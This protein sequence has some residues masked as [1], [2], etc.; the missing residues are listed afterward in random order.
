M[1]QHFTSFVISFHR[2]WN[3]RELTKLNHSSMGT[4]WLQP[5]LF[6]TPTSNVT[7][8]LSYMIQLD[9]WRRRD[10][11]RSQQGLDL[12]SKPAMRI[13][14][15]EL[16]ILWGARSYFSQVVNGY[17]PYSRWRGVKHVHGNL[18]VHF[19]LAVVG[20][21]FSPYVSNCKYISTKQCS[22][23]AFVWNCTFIVNRTV[24]VYKDKIH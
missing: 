18:E 3:W 13:G 10:V 11:R 17:A 24:Q 19:I 5:S 20:V 12:E 2:K 6:W 4:M 9:P 16:R 22:P 7:L 15:K 21:L 1:F 14:E 8:R 23:Y